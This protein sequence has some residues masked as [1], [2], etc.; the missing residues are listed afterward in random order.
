MAE[1]Y[2]K[3]RRLTEDTT[4]TVKVELTR[5]FRARVWLGLLLIRTA[6]WVMGCR[7]EVMR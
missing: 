7:I 1:A 6:A 2:A 3:F 4:L 5:E